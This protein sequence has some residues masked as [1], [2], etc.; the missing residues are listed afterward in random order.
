MRT[1]KPNKQ[2]TFM[3]V[4]KDNT[5]NETFN[6]VWITELEDIWDTTGQIDYDSEKLEEFKKVFGE[7]CDYTLKEIVEK[8]IYKTDINDIKDYYQGK[9][10]S[11]GNNYLIDCINDSLEQEHDIEIISITDIRD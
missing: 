3:V 5:T 11:N 2:Y 7:D 9:N 1:Y 4:Y 8:G 6:W 10:R